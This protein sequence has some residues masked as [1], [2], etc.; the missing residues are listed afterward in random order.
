MQCVQ[1][2]WLA[3]R[4]GDAQKVAVQ[5]EIDN[6]GGQSLVW[7][8]ASAASPAQLFF[9][10]DAAKALPLI[11]TELPQESVV[12]LALGESDYSELGLE[13]IRTFKKAIVP[14]MV[15]FFCDK[16]TEQFQALNLP[17][18]KVLPS[19]DLPA[20]M[21]PILRFRSVKSVKEA[22]GMRDEVHL[23][24]GFQS[25]RYCTS[26]NGKNEPGFWDGETFYCLVVDDEQRDSLQECLMRYLAD[27]SALQHVGRGSPS[28]WYS[29]ESEHWQHLFTQARGELEA[30]G[31]AFAVE[32]GFRHDYVMADNWHVS[33]EEGD[34]EHVHLEVALTVGDARVD[35]RDLLEQLR[36]FIRQQSVTGCKN[37]TGN[38]SFELGDGRLLLIPGDQLTGI[39]EELGDL[40]DGREKGFRIAR[41]QLHRLAGLHQQLPAN[42]EWVGKTAYLEK[43]VSLHKSPIM[44]DKELS[45]VDATLRPYQ[46]LGVCWMQHLKQHNINGLLADDMGLGKTLQTIAHLSFEQQQ[47]LLHCPA[48]IIVPTSLLHN[49]QR[50]IERFASQLRCKIMHGVNRHQ[51]WEEL[52]NYDVIISSYQ[53]VAN[54]LERWQAQAL[55]WLILDEAQAIKNPRTRA[56]KAVRELN[57]P[58]RL[59]LSGT[60]VENHLGELWSILDFLMPGCLGSAKAFKSH[61]QKPIEQDGNSNRL[62]HLLAR[63]EP[64]MLRR[65]KDQIASDLPAKTEI[66]QTI[67]L[68]PDQ[69]AFY[70]HLKSSSWNS[71]QQQMDDTE[72][73]G[74][75]HMLVL[76]ALLK[77]RQ[78]CCDPTLLGEPTISSAKREYCVN[79]L[80]E[81][82]AEGRAVLV[83]SQFTS[84]LDL[85]AESLDEE[86]I[87]YLMLV[88]KTRNRQKVVDAFQAGEAPVFLISL[89]AGGTGL[90]LTA[91]DTVIHYDPW[92]N[93]AAERQATDRSHRIGQNKPVFVYKLI[94]ENTIEEKIAKLQQRKALLSEHI[95]AQAQLSGE[96]FAFKL[97]EL[98]ALWHE[99]N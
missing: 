80:C 29:R 90:N 87:K 10:Q 88:G 23:Q 44:L 46:W 99:D 45:C 14:A 37:L 93:Q 38:N 59:C 34:D 17:L 96:A 94:A 22:R 60:P 16:N 69:Q 82:V 61:F 2:G 21:V 81:L 43:A 50:E 20:T 9:L 95:N 40:L 70:S 76:T 8:S 66:S 11:C 79:M 4:E 15:Q 64:F 41:S 53:L 18:P 92:W 85:L 36:E 1:G 65:N 35:L 97:E 33:L 84:M 48:L 12:E 19:E 42:T 91:A 74:Q 39:V 25:D 78:A 31:V 68:N 47:G 3:L 57:C 56:S 24:F 67:P 51:Y 63:I 27:F 62:K 28:A 58:N 55:S 5:W 71:L 75:Q 98:I 77:L 73:N 86:G 83:F 13:C 49:W 72:R 6:Q 54:D 89:K 32:P 7:R 52:G 26:E 30:Q